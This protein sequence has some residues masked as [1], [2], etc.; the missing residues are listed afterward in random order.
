M[1]EP[2]ATPTVGVAASGRS[3]LRA[4]RGANWWASKL[5]PLFGLA[6]IQI[7]RHPLEPLPA[8]AL[9]GG[10]LLVTGGAVGA[11]GHVL[12]DTFDIAADRRAGRSNR[13]AGLRPASRALLAGGLLVVAFAPAPV[14]G[15]G[16]T[17]T[18]LLGLEVLLPALYSMPPVRLKE[19]GAAG[20]LADAGAAHA[21]PALIVMTAF[22]HAA[23][24]AEDPTLLLVVGV[25]SLLLGLDG[26][27]WHQRLDRDSDLRAGS[28]TFATAAAPTLLESLSQLIWAGQAVSSL[29]MVVVLAPVAPLLAWA[30][31]LC[32]LL[33]LLRLALG[34]QWLPDPRRPELAR[35]HLPLRSN[36]C[37]EVWFPAAVALQLALARP[38]YAVLPLLL[39]ALFWSN[40]REQAA[41]LA[42]LGRDLV[43]RRPRRPPRPPALPRRAGWTLE[44]FAG[45]TARLARSSA[46]RAGLRVE[47]GE[48]GRE[49]WHVKL[50]RGPVALRRGSVVELRAEMRADRPR[51]V[52][53]SAVR[54]R[55]PWDALGLSEQLEIPAGWCS[56]R[57]GFTAA[58]DAAADLCLLLGDA[59]AA[60]ELG[61][62]EIAELGPAG[63]E[64]QA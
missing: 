17:A 33:D 4:V 56:V 22:A 46:G 3:A 27:L 63:D 62:V 6:C 13:M 21:V 51:P 57:L 54:H 37:Y 61:R 15:Y 59:A 49:C 55:P 20:L 11:W 52:T 2:R 28:R 18:L 44:L 38:S 16:R 10:V 24:A 60:V 39:A 9:L 12:N 14:L 29:V 30:V 1:A 41:D 47:I 31:G 53:W 45:A 25:W 19:R 58:E 5:P 42:A 35:R 26:I 34:W 64:G 8:L 32:L 23:G 48:P 40:L 43:R 50:S 7:L 36:A